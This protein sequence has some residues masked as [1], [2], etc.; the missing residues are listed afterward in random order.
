MSESTH[1]EPSAPRHMALGVMVHPTGNHVASWLHPQA[2]IDAGTN[3]EHYVEVAQIA[4]RGKL[5]FMFLADAVATRDGNLEALSR[6]PQYMVF[7]DPLTLL[8]GIAARTSHI[9]LAATITTSY[10]EPYNVARRIASLDHMSGGRCIWNIV[11]SANL[12]EAYNFGREEHYG[13]EERYERAAEFVD[14]VTGLLDSWD[15]DAL[16]RDRASQR[17]FDPEKLHFLRHKGEHFSVRGPLNTSRPP[18]GYPVFALASASETGKEL[19]GRVAEIVFTPLHNLAQG[20]ALYQDLKA[21]AARF[22]RRPED[23]K[24]VPGLNPVIGR[25]RKEAEEK[26]DYLRSLIHPDV[27]KELLSNALGNLDLSPYGPEDRLPEATVDQLMATNNPRFKAFLSKERTIREMYEIYAG[28]RG[29]RTILGSPSEIADEMTYW[30]REQ[31][32]D[33][34]LVHP[35]VFPTHLEEFVDLVIPELQERGVFRT[36]YTGKTVRENLGLTR[37]ASRYAVPAKDAVPA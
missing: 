29:Q 34:F 20:Q 23:L 15:D 32:V 12:S 21:R 35:S 11:T 9:G 16:V 1:A 4:E 19:A 37:P 8:A 18:Q 3:F 28:A 17:Y 25:T 36:E 33:G 13:H 30:F 2:Q 27:G 5:D 22:G 7:F 14:V 31:A 10:N 24:V 6:W 26:F